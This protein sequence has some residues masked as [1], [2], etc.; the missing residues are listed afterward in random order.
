MALKTRVAI[1]SALIGAISMALA[2]AAQAGGDKVAFP[3]NFM[4]GK[5]YTTVDRPDNKQYRELYTSP[6]AIEAAKKGQPMPSGTVVTLVDA[7]RDHTEIRVPR[8]TSVG[9][10]HVWLKSPL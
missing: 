3:Q 8:P 5:L 7:C 6:D 4:S 1:S 10:W 9:G 2:V